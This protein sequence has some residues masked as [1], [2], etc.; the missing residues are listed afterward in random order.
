LRTIQAQTLLQPLKAMIL[1]AACNLE[2]DI[3]QKIVAARADETSRIGQTILQEILENAD[4]AS[5]EHLPI[6]QDTG[7]AVFF[8]SKGVDCFVEGGLTRIIQ[9]ATAEAYREGYLRK[10]M[11]SDPLD[12]INTNDNT[13]AVIWL[14]ECD[15]DQL[16]ISFTAKGGGA[17]NMSAIKML[18][19]SDG[20]SGIKE[21]VVETVKK[22]GGNACPPMIIGVGIGGTFEKCAWLAK[23]ALLRSI[24]E[25]NS[26][27]YYANLEKE[28]LELVNST[29]VGPQGLGGKTTA[30]GLMIE[31]FPRHIASLPVAVN[32]QCH[33][34]RH[35]T[36][37]I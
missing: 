29:G 26:N 20:V 1:D 19:P 36:I 4:I 3:R 7:V 11:L 34:S 27:Q 23:K 25:P 10:S 33:A 2:C 32:I 28:L 17:E 13:P 5:K 30:L 21:F 9:Q 14:E 22:A 12:G 18:K 31:S 37:T 8:V 16:T 24:S 15:G 6:C 35:K